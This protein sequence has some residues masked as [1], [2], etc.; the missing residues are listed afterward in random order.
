L[1]ALYNITGIVKVLIDE[2]VDLSHIH[3]MS[4]ANAVAKMLKRRILEW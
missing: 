4:T 2:E 3:I 1:A